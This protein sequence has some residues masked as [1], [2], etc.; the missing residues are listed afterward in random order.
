MSPK[1]LKDEALETIA[2]SNQLMADLATILGVNLFSMPMM[3][4]RKS[5]RFMELPALTIIAKAMKCKPEDLLTES[6]SKIPA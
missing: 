4:Q 1:V 5:K 3:L 6:E 2:G